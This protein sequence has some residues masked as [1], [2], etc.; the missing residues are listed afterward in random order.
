MQCS[1][2]YENTQTRTTAEVTPGSWAE[3]SRCIWLS[4]LRRPH[5]SS[6]RIYPGCGFKKWVLGAQSQCEDGADTGREGKPAGG[7][8]G[9]RLLGSNHSREGAQEETDE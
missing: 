4:D 7:T 8:V 9:P 5:R 2:N 1:G 3:L 6:I